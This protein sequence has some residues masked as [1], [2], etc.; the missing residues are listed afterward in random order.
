MRN[1]KKWINT[2]FDAPGLNKI[3]GLVVFISIIFLLMITGLWFFEHESFWD[4]AWHAW[5]TMTT[6]GYGDMPAQTAGGK[7]V[8]VGFGTM[9]IALL[10]ALFSALFDY[11]QSFINQ[12]L[13]GFMENP[14]KGGYVIF[15]F[16][17]DY[18]M[19][20]IIRELRS[21][22][23]EVGI[24][25]VDSILEKLPEKIALL[26]NIH[27]VKGEILD[28][29]TYQRAGIANNEAVVV[30]P[31]TPGQPSSD[32][33]TQM[34]VSLINKFTKNKT[35]VIYVLVDPRNSWMFE[36]LACTRV[37][38]SFEILAIVQE[39]QDVYSA[40]VA[41]DLLLNSGGANIK[42]VRPQKIVG[43][44]WYDFVHKTLELNKRAAKGC[45][46]LAI[47]R[48]HENILCPASTEKILASDMLSIVA[49]N[50]FEWSKFESELLTV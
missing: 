45:N 9:G 47:I 37:F 46:P 8:I 43:W 6:V 38:E 19:L 16:P 23:P 20:K 36:D 12:K 41:E 35:R 1:L 5:Q 24:C 27:F 39:C 15:N 33:I 44:S 30:F 29:D 21:Y 26:P 50:D 3:S 13:F 48:D 28:K 17:G 11:R 40:S 22:E 31:S 32:G 4:A 14:I 25:I 2:L 34:T 7:I 18:K 42:S 10:G 49:F